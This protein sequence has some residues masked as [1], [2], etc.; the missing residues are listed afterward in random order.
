[1]YIEYIGICMCVYVSIYIYIHFN[2]H[3]HVLIHMHAYIKKHMSKLRHLRRWMRTQYSQPA[4]FT[5]EYALAELWRSRGLEPCAVSWS[6]D[7]QEIRQWWYIM[8]EIWMIHNMMKHMECFILRV[9]VICFRLLLRF[10]ND[11]LTIQGFGPQRGWICCRRRGR[12]AF[13]ILWP[14]G[15]QTVDITWWL[16]GSWWR[17]WWCASI[18]HSVSDVW[19][20]W[21]W[22]YK[23]HWSAQ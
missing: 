1:M 19:G 3:M 6:H 22:W 16:V 2:I 17:C 18:I 8:I 12:S 23:T 14:L 20:Q 13:D 21:K 5:V 11:S 7:W 9:H 15:I 4:I 10:W